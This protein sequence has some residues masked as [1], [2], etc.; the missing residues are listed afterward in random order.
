MWY[1]GKAIG[2]T[3]HLK[4]DGGPASFR[5]AGDMVEHHDT[6]E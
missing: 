5:G 1:G 3:A 4:H 6:R 2:I